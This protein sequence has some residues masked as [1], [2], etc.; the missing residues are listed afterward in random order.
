MIL[1]RVLQ[2]RG[3]YIN[4]NLSSQETPHI[5][6]SRATYG[7]SIVR[8]WEKTDHVIMAPLCIM[9]WFLLLPQLLSSVAQEAPDRLPML[10]GEEEQLAQ[11]VMVAG[12][13]GMVPPATPETRPPGGPSAVSTPM[14]RV[15]SAKRN[16]VAD[17]PLS[18][19]QEPAV[20]DA[21]WEW[22]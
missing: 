4:R 10:P 9:T 6:Q 1:D 13:P 17:S 15:R 3:H 20:S 5:S 19:A 12:S 14:P 16:A 8:I 11:S 21:L 22:W 7:L 18:R 2:L